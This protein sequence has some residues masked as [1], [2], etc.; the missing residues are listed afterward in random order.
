MFSFVTS[1]PSRAWNFFKRNKYRLGLLGAAGGAA[2][3]YYGPA[4][5]NAFAL[6]KLMNEMGAKESHEKNDE[7]DQDLR[8]KKTTRT[9][10]ETATDL[11]GPIRDHLEDTYA[12]ELIRVQSE[13]RTTESGPNREKLFS[14]LLML[15]FSRL[16]TAIT[17][18]RY[19]LLLARVEVGLIGKVHRKGSVAEDLRA[20]HRDLLS[21][22]RCVVASSVF[23]KSVDAIC[24]DVVGEVFRAKGV[25]PTSKY[26]K[27]KGMNDVLEGVV[28]KVVGKL[29]LNGWNWVLGPDYQDAQLPY[30]CMQTLD[31]LDSPQWEAVT[32]Y[33]LTETLVQALDR[34]TSQQSANNV[35]PFASLLPGMKAEIDWILSSNE[36]LYS[37]RFAESNL[38]NEFS[39]NVYFDPVEESDANSS[40]GG[41]DAADIEKLGKLLEKLVS[42]DMADK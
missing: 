41:D 33:V 14:Q 36:T 6:Y 27:K 20:D 4:I 40:V 28:E 42:T 3:Y 30:I 7:S 18:N 2:W 11:F 35:V 25:S 23:V 37:Q 34:I 32:R 1:I 19:A 31:V 24:R 9:S 38:V 26:N 22:F 16:V 17:V 5:R 13:L 39:A 21:A 8:F 29:K 12:S 15:Y 10:D